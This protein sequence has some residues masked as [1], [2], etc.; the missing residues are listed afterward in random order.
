MVRTVAYRFFDRLALDGQGD[1]PVSTEPV[2]AEA[3][4]GTGPERRRAVPPWPGP[5]C[6]P[7]DRI[8]RS[9]GLAWPASVRSVAR[10]PS[11]RS[12]IAKTETCASGTPRPSRLRIRPS[13]GTSSRRR[14]ITTGFDGGL[15]VD[16]DPCGPERRGPGRRGARRHRRRPSSP[17]GFRRSTRAGSRPRNGRPHRWSRGARQVAGRR[18]RSTTIDAPATGLPSGSRT[19]P[20]KTSESSPRFPPGWCRPSLRGRAAS[21]ARHPGYQGW[22]RGFIRRVERRGEPDRNARRRQDEKTSGRPDTGEHQGPGHPARQG[23][24][25]GRD[26]ALDRRAGQAQRAAA[27]I[28]FWTSERRDRSAPG[29]P[30]RHRADRPDSVE[31]QAA[32][33]EPAP[34]PVPCPR[35]PRQH[36]AAGAAQPPRG[37]LGAQALEV[38]Q[39]DRG[40]E[41]LGQ[42]GPPRRSASRSPDRRR[43]GSPPPPRASSAA[44]PSEPRGGGVAGRRRRRHAPRPAARCGTASPPTDSRLRIGIRLA[45][46]EQERGLEGVVGVVRIAQDPLTD[47]QDHR[48]MP[49]DQRGE[50]R[51]GFRGILP[52]QEPS[53]EL[54]VTPFSDR[55]QADRASRVDRTSR[56][57]IVHEPSRESFQAENALWVPL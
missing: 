5:A 48:S 34:Q 24:D 4:I 43:A 36:R 23:G 47:A 38:M 45:D 18:G 54:A 21:Q 53:Q 50:R 52:G 56:R 2:H 13:I 10:N 46:Q 16:L 17:A 57:R 8:H 55:A 9:L 32:S 3:A 37:G 27:R 51:L 11:G 22:A 39:H 35:Q 1:D 26:D 28:V 12:A 49:F 40:A 33:F 25:G 6:F 29:Q 41:P 20:R 42:A 19:C 31:R 15:A 7:S 14:R 44:P 30:I